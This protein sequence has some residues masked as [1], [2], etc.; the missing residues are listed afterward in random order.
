M[1]VRWT[2]IAT[3]ILAMSITGCQ[4]ADGS[5]EP[6]QPRAPN[7]IGQVVPPQVLRDMDGK[8]VSLSARIRDRPTLMMIMDRTACLTCANFPLE[9]KILGNRYPSL[10]MIVV[11][12]GS[13]TAFLKQYFRRHHISRHTLLDLENQLLR[14]LGG[15]ELNSLVLLLDKNGRVILVDERVG[16]Q[17][18][19]FPISQRLLALTTSLD[20]TQHPEMP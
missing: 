10:N 5:A 20:A 17:F 8:A 11:A 3:L 2:C 18:A 4:I 16:A 9:L 13:D 15:P 7:L 12:S 6:P 19:Q 14:A 1:A